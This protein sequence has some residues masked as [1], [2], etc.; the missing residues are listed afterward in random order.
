MNPPANHDELMDAVIT[1]VNGADPEWRKSYEKALGIRTNEKRYRDW[2]TLKYLLRGIETN[3]P[4]IRN[5]YLVVSSESQIPEWASGELRIVLHKDIIPERYLP[6]FNSSIIELFLHNIQG[7]D[8]EFV[9]FNDDMF[10][11]L[12]CR[13]EDFFIKGKA[14]MNFRRCLLYPGQYKKQTRNSY[15]LACKASGIKPGPI[16]LRQQHTATTMFRS[17]N[18]RVFKQM[19]DDILPQISALRTDDNINQTFYLDYMKV[20]G[21]CVN[22]PLKKRHFS[23]ATIAVEKRLKKF[24]S[25]PDCQMICV[26]DCNVSKKKFSSTAAAFIGALESRFNRKSRFEK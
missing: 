17:V 22:S 3:M 11:I 25:K 26:N 15:R 23:L 20:N 19:E 12:P 16:F 13:P 8:E 24:F 7:I 9:Y 6:T 4:F 1:Y 21:L 10:P 5:V 14:A 2:G 18:E